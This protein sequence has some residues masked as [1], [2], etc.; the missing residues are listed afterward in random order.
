MKNVQPALGSLKMML[1]Q[2]STNIL[3]TTWPTFDVEMEL[4][5]KARL[6]A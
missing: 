4:T 1:C 6:D 2:S 5:W 3:I